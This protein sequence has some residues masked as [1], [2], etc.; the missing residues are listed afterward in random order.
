MISRTL[1]LCPDRLSLRN[2]FVSTLDCISGE[3]FTFDVKKALGTSR[4]RFNTQLANIPYKF[5]KYWERKFLKLANRFIYEEF[6]K[7]EPEIVL[8]YNSEY[9]L[10]ETCFEF[11]KRSQLIFFLGDS[12][13]YTHQN[14]FFLKCLSYADLIL[15]PDSFWIQQLNVIGLKRTVFFFPGIDLKSYNTII[16]EKTERNFKNLDILYVG[17]SYKNSWGYKKALLM[18]HF[19]DFNFR[20]F[21]NSAWEKWFPLF[22]ELEKVFTKTGY[23][24][25]NKL[26]E[27]FNKS[28]IIPVDGNPAIINGVHLRLLESLGSGSFPL[29]E[30]R[31]DLENEVFSDCDF[32]IPFINDYSK[33]TDIAKYWLAHD[34]ERIQLAGEMRSHVIKRYSPENNASIIMRRLKV[35]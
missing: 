16:Q 32:R 11:K 30:Y 17:T 4:L 27:M 13:L 2:V 14:Y 25:A 19:I 20:I 7:V 9:L 1:I 28:K 12:P 35:S 24:N 8:I 26:N 29:I 23:I 31:V 3:T 33:A 10:P 6:K 22:P 15:V 18:S 5:R 21:G 34:L